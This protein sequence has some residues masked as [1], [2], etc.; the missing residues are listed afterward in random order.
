MKHLIEF[1]VRELIRLIFKIKTEVELWDTK[2]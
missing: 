2:S 1:I